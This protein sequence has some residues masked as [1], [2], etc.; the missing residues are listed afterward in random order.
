MR[1]FKLFFQ[2]VKRPTMS[3]IDRTD[4]I[5]REVGRLS[6]QVSKDRED[7]LHKKMEFHRDK[8]KLYKQQILDKYRSK[9]KAQARK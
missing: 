1:L 4:K 2:E 5:N 8:Y 9:V 3:Y 7:A 6:F